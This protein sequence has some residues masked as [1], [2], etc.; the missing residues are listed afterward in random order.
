M[1]YNQLVMP[2]YINGQARVGYYR[3]D[4]SCSSG[5][6]STV[7]VSDKFKGSMGQLY[8]ELLLG[9]RR[10]GASLGDFGEQSA[11]P[12]EIKTMS[13]K[14][15]TVV[16]RKQSGFARTVFGKLKRVLG[17]KKKIKSGKSGVKKNGF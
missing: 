2:I 14:A 17:L 3:N 11:L 4:G 16:Q 12:I 1:L 8:P 5:S 7:D 10:N 6:S 13:L 15:I 9:F